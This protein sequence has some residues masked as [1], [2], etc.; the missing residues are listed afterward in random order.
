M[1]D[2]SQKPK[3]AVEP[4]AKNTPDSSGETELSGNS[5]PNIPDGPPPKTS[6]LKQF[7]SPNNKFLFIFVALVIAIAVAAFIGLR[8]ARNNSPQNAKTNS[9]TDQQIAALKGTTTLVGDSQQ[10][11]DIQSN[12]VFEGQVLL[13]GSLSV[14]G[15]IKVGGG[16]SLPSITVG[17]TSNFS[18]V[19][20]NSTLSVAGNT[21]LQGQVNIQKNLT[22]AGSGSFGSLSASQLSASTL[23]LSGDL[24]L[25][26]HITT[27]GG[28]PSKAN[29]T[30]LGS[31]GTAS[32]S[33]SDT[34]G[35]V[36]VNTGSG[37]PAGCFVTINFS[38][39]FSST[40]HVVISPSNSS[41]GALSYYTNRYATGFSICTASTPASGTTYLFDYIVVG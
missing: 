36:S 10:T 13:R 40:P 5:Q 21:T 2:N 30:A 41:A 31:G 22:V 29:G 12:A 34:A 7:L 26:H 15:S 3:D 25:S 24:V 9:L 14:A 33:G 37:P 27:N 38:Q 4:A 35:T 39:R 32:V 19:E 28:G 16:L 1:E 23:Q 8:A 18:Q 20:V 17:G 6:R 11:L